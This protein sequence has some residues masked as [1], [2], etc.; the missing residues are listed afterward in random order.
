MTVV[1]IVLFVVGFDRSLQLIPTMVGVSRAVVLYLHRQ[2]EKK[3][4]KMILLD[5]QIERRSK[6]G[7]FANSLPL[8]IVYIG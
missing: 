2:R 1:I 8:F 5:E 4:G 7:S 3:P 6:R